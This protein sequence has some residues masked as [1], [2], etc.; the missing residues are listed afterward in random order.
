MKKLTALILMLIIAGCST[1]N[2][3]PT[4]A[5]STDAAALAQRQRIAA[6]ASETRRGNV[7]KGRQ[8]DPA[9]RM[10]LDVYVLSVPYGTIS[11][12]EEFWKRVNE[13][14]VDVATYDLLIKNGVR[15]GEAPIA[16]YERFRQTIAEQPASYR[17]A[18]LVNPEAKDVDL[19]IRKEVPSQLIWHYN[20]MNELIGWSYDRCENYVTLSYQPAPRKNG[21]I[22]AVL[23]PVVK[24]HRKRLEW[25]AGNKEQEVTFTQPRRY[26][27]VNLK[28][29]VAVGSFLIVAP[30]AEATWP[31][32]IGNR[33]FVQ[34]GA[35]EQMESVL[36]LVP[37]RVAVTE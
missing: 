17:V 3:A 18:E 26:Y 4:T 6:Y 29:D 33:F 24:E 21:T 23:C 16:E 8:A 14:A 22:R 15:V 1:A 5:A 30:S 19:E 2:P 13:Q 20:G 31:G 36:L 25:L 11:R 37:R 7:A 35:A 34:E 28:A 32:S 27:D 12:N 10:R 9:M